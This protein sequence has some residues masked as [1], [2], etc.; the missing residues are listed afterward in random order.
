MVGLHFSSALIFGDRSP[1]FAAAALLVSALMP[2]TKLRGTIE[3]AI[4]RIRI[5]SDDTGR[6][7]KLWQAFVRCIV[8]WAHI[9]FGLLYLTV[10]FSGTSRPR[11]CG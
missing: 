9:A 8:S 2:L 4:F 11:F 7:M 3:K 10:V 6:R 1:E 5:V